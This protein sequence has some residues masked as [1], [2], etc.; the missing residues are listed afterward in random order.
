LN[1]NFG[2]GGWQVGIYMCSIGLWEFPG[3][4]CE[5]WQELE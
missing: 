1:M 4:W 2:G 3:G 5:V